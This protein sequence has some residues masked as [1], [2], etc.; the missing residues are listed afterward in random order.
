[1]MDLF[2]PEML[3]PEDTLRMLERLLEKITRSESMLDSLHD[4]PSLCRLIRRVL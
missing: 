3:S 1:M 2:A 4:N